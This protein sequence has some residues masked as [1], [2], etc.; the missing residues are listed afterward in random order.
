MSSM[1]RTRTTRKT[2]PAK[3][4]PFTCPIEENTELGLAMLIVED[5]DGAYEPVGVVA[6]LAEAR[7]IAEDDFG[8]RLAAVERD[9]TPI[10]PAVYRVFSRGIDGGFH[11]A[12]RFSF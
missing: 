8:R 10:V 5:E 2:N 3:R 4:S 1:K 6:T 12:R 9:E 11:E 7:E